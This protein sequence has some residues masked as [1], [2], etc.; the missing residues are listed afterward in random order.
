MCWPGCQSPAPLLYLHLLSLVHLLLAVDML[1][2]R[3]LKKVPELAEATLSL[4]VLFLVVISCHVL[5]AP[6]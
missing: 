5:L 4:V 1:P 2:G 3:Q 6:V